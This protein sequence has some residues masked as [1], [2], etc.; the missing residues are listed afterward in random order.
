MSLQHAAAVAELMTELFSEPQYGADDCEYIGDPRRCPVHPHIET[1]SADGMFDGP[2]GACE[3][4]MESEARQEEFEMEST[5]S[6]IVSDARPLEAV[7]MEAREEDLAHETVKAMKE[8][9]AAIDA[10]CPF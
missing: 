1:S 4:E 9:Q 8:A 6:R 5:A 3:F 10:E 2:C 7:E